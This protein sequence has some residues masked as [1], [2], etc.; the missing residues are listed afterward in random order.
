MCPSV[1]D[2]RLS[3][4]ERGTLGENRYPAKSLK[5]IFSRKRVGPVFVKDWNDK[6]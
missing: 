6:Q 4:V 2:Y 3:T 1:N 5:S